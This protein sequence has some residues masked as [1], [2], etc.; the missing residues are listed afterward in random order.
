MNKT[1]IDWCDY[2]WNPVT[3]CLHGCPYCYARVIAGRFGKMVPDFSAYPK[4]HPGCHML[5]SEISG[6]PYPWI[7]EPTFHAAHLDE[8]QHLKKPSTIFVVSMGDLF[9]E[10]VPDEWIREVFAA[11][12]AAPQHRY[13]FLT[14]NYLHASKFKFHS[15]WWIGKTVTSSEDSRLFEGDPWSTDITKRA[16]HFL[17]IEPIHGPIPDLPYYAHEYGFRWVIVGA[18]T[19]PEAKK[20]RPQREWIE[21]IVKDCAFRKVPVFLKSSLKDI[22]GKPLMQEYPW[23]EAS[24]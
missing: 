6:N 14:K 5:D 24:T 9:G 2:T 12:E 23:E 21:Q 16:N 15:N 8:P 11:C 20:N 13:L 3:G 1:K 7:F 19:G 4:D 22:W 10:W 17:S 18:E